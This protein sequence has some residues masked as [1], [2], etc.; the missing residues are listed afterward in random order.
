MVAGTNI[1]C[2]TACAKTVVIIRTT[3]DHPAGAGLIRNE[4]VVPTHYYPAVT[5]NLGFALSDGGA[6]DWRLGW[7]LTSAA[8]GDQGFDIGLYAIRR[9]A[10]SD[11]DTPAEHG[12]MLHGAIRR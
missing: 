1:P 9:E 10:A 12:V 8:R 11:D 6:R 4:V 3:S 2:A 7:R 5:P